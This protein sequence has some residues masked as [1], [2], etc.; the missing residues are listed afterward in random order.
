MTFDKAYAIWDKP[1][2]YDRVVFDQ[3]W[4]GPASAH[5]LLDEDAVAVD[6]AGVVESIVLFVI[7]MLRMMS[8]RS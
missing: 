7:S 8:P 6:K 3:H 5:A 2:A 4:A 1:A